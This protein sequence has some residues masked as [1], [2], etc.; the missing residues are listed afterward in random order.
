MKI[1]AGIDDAR[2]M[3]GGGAGETSTL[4]ATVIQEQGWGSSQLAS[5][6]RL[7]PN[8]LT[9][10]RKHNTARS[11]TAEIATTYLPYFISYACKEIRESSLSEA[12]AGLAIIL[13]D[14]LED[15]KDLIDYAFRVKECMVDKDEAL[16]LA[17][18]P[19]ILL[20]E[21][22]GNGK[23]IVGALA[24]AGLRMTGNDG[25]FRGKLRIG[26]GDGYIA[27]VREIIL[28]S[29][30]QQVKTM[31]FEVLE[32][33]EQV[34]MG[35]KVKVVLLDDMYTLL[36]YPTGSKVPMWQTSTTNMLRTF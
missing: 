18:K 8:P 12:N 11:F 29:H 3:D 21:L 7:Y 36:V 17:K 14:Q 27:T 19:G 31:D 10:Y 13:L 4:L 35:E 23:G 33:N 20:Y 15:C 25:Q 32:S 5:R 22:S 30:V 9:G 26:T 24:G 16:T 1:I 34:R 6:H 2:R 28:T